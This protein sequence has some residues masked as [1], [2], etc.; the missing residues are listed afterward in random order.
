MR[1]AIAA[2]TITLVLIAPAFACQTVA[3]CPYDGGTAIFSGQ[4]ASQ[5]GK[6]FGKF[7][8]RGY[9]SKGHS[10]DHESWQP[11]D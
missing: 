11:C 10:F 2:L 1:P 7:V 8:H 9:D 3:V 5:N 6:Q 4:T